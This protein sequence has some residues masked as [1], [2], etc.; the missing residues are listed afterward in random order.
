MLITEPFKNAHCAPKLH[1]SSHLLFEDGCYDP[2]HFI[3]GETE[4]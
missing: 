1:A 4:V 3:D 2:H